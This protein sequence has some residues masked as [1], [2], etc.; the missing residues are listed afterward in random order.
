MH[1]SVMSRI[2]CAVYNLDAH[3]HTN[4]HSK[5]MIGTFET[6]TAAYLELLLAL[7]VGQLLGLPVLGLR[8]LVALLLVCSWV[9]P[10]SSVHLPK[11][12]VTVSVTA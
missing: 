12:P 10:D 2:Y 3:M 8:G 9:L 1:G 4:T 6:A 7:V 5:H 11:D